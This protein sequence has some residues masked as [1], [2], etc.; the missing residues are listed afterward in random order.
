MLLLNSSRK[1][2]MASNESYFKYFEFSWIQKEYLTSELNGPHVLLAE[3][4][5]A[6]QREF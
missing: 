4:K 2:A 6:F 3:G 5:Q 1:F